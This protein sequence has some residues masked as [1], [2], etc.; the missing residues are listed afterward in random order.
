[1]TSTSD[2]TDILDADAEEERPKVEDTDAED[3]DYAPRARPSTKR[4]LLATTFMP[5]RR[6]L[7][8]GRWIGWPVGLAWLVG[9]ITALQNGRI[10]RAEFIPFVAALYACAGFFAHA[11]FVAWRAGTFIRRMTA[12]ILS[13]SVLL[14]L[15]WLHLDEADSRILYVDGAVLPKPSQPRYF[16]AIAADGIAASLLMIHSF[17][18]GFGSRRALTRAERR[19]LERA[20]KEG[21]KKR[22]AEAKSAL[23]SDDDAA[24]RPAESARQSP[25]ETKN[26]LDEA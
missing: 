10:Y 19:A 17:I 18:L 22:E 23:E 8:D 24:E 4:S 5:R 14:L 26:E 7:V 1:M 9:L 12:A 13:I 3:S 6:G 15:M 25:D 21:R 20:R 2:A 11:Y 16:V